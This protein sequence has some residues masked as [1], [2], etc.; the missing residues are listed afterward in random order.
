M[1]GWIARSQVFWDEVSSPPSSQRLGSI[2]AEMPP[3][4]LF[5]AN[6][7]AVCHV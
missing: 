6:D 5:L 3:T 2:T 1:T 4:I 7:G